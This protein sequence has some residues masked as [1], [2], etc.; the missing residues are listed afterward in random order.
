MNDLPRF[1]TWQCGAGSRTRDLASPE[2]SLHCRTVVV[3]VVVVVSYV[4]VVTV[5]ILVSSGLSF[6]T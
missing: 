4:V 2:H 3:V 5:T 1:A 6:S